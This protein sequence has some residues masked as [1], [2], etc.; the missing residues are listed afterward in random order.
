MRHAWRAAAGSRIPSCSALSYG[1]P[2]CGPGWRACG[3]RGRSAT[4]RGPAAGAGAGG[5]AP[6]PRTGG[7]PGRWSQWVSDTR[8]VCV[9]RRQLSSKAQCTTPPAGAGT[10]GRGGW[11]VR[12]GAQTAGSRGGAAPP[13][14]GGFVRSVRPWCQQGGFAQSCGLVQGL[15]AKVN[16]WLASGVL[17]ARATPWRVHGVPACRPQRLVGSR[18]RLRQADRLSGPRALPIPS[19]FCYA[20]IRVTNRTDMALK[21]AQQKA[22][23]GRAASRRNAVVVRAANGAWGLLKLNAPVM[24][25]AC[26]RPVPGSIALP[27]VHPFIRSRDAAARA[28]ASRLCRGLPWLPWPPLPCW[29]PAPWTPRSFSRSRS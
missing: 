19:P 25:R 5:G 4:G 7:V 2:T 26:S 1:S 3:G 22:F 10:A 23:G 11:W 27:P 29:S 14:P 12:M 17:G 16:T 24:G 18:Q 13:P 28:Q 6:G 8:V 21:A 9:G 15:A 20:F